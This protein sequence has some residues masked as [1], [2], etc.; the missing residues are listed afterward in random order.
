[1]QINGDGT[2]E[3]LSATLL[4]GA[5]IELTKDYRVT[6]PNFFLNG[7]DDFKIVREWYT[8]RE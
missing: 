1:M 6:I 5:P 4:D 2:K 7:G 3:F 8:P